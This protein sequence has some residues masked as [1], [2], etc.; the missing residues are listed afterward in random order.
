[1]TRLPTDV[2]IGHLTDGLRQLNRPPR[3]K[4]QAAIDRTLLESIERRLARAV[5]RDRTGHIERDGYP[6][7]TLGPDGGRTTPGSRTETAALSRPERDQHHE[8]TALAVRRLTDA[9]TALGGL[10]STLNAIDDLTNDRGP[11]VRFCAHCTGKRGPD[12][13][14]PVWRRG[15]VGNRLITNVDLCSPCFHFVEQTA[16]AGSLAGYLP[17]DEQIRDHELRGRW[18]IRT[19]RVVGYGG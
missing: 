6:T 5:T 3:D 17:S 7:S 16:L 13:D 9:V 1:V 11:D 15:T 4:P 8:L 12:R 10:V 2:T 18:R 14:L 19:L